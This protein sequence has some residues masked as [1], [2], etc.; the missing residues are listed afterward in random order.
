APSALV[1]LAVL[2]DELGTDLSI[3]QSSV[4]S[5]VA[6]KPNPE[7]R[8]LLGRSSSEEKDVTGVKAD[9]TSQPAS[10]S[11]PAYGELLDVMTHTTTRLSLGWSAEKQERAPSNRLDEHFLAGHRR[12][13]PPSLPFLPELHSE[14]LSKSNYANIKGLE[15]SGYTKMPQM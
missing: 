4:T 15:D 9:A 1:G 12:S 3:S 6:L 10:S 11:S 13:A 2:A 14:L 5:L 8:M 7:A